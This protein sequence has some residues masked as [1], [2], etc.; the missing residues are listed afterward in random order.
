[1]KIGSRLHGVAIS[2]SRSPRAGAART[3]QDEVVRREMIFLNG[4]VRKTNNLVTVWQSPTISGGGP[5][6]ID[7]ILAR[8]M[9]IFYFLSGHMKE[10]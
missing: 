9:M 4:L 8:F 7:H 10:D 5:T 3:H 2:E 6:E 1:M